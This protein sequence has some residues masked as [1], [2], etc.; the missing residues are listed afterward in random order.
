MH[1]IISVNPGLGIGS[2]WIDDEIKE[3]FNLNFKDYLNFSNP[4]N[5]LNLKAMWIVFSKGGGG[6]EFWI[7]NDTCQLIAWAMCCNYPQFRMPMKKLI[8]K[9][10]QFIKKMAKDAPYWQDYPGFTIDEVIV[11]PLKLKSSNVR[12]AELS[13]SARIHLFY[14]LHKGGGSLPNLTNYSIRSF[15]IRTEV[16]TSEILDSQLLIES[17]EPASLAN[18]LTKKELYDNCSKAMVNYRKSWNK[19]KLAQTLMQENNH[20]YS[21][22][23]EQMNIVDINPDYKK[24]LTELYT[25]AERLIPA[26]KVLCFI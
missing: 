22:L 18:S 5:Y 19:V 9:A 7:T 6:R 12:I 17:H 3:I 20:Y 16:T 2:G 21:K 23:I 14:V 8:K 4:E 25:Y 10:N 24:D 15:G 26:F 1:K 11:E 13:L